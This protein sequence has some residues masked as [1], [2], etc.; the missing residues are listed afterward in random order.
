MHKS[1]I[2]KSRITELARL[3]LVLAIKGPLQ[4]GK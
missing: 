2:K 4:A 1:R 3:D